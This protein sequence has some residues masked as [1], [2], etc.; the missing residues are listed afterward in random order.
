MG[1]VRG[2]GLWLRTSRPE[3]TRL[4][5]DFLWRQWRQLGLGGPGGGRWDPWILDPEALLLFSLEVGRSDPILY[6]QVLGWLARHERLINVSRLVR[7]MGRDSGF[8]PSLV[9]SVARWLSRKSS[10][11]KWKGLEGRKRSPLR[12]FFLSGLTGRL[13]GLEGK[14]PEFEAC[15]WDR[16]PVRP[17]REP[18]PIPILRVSSLVLRLRLLLGV[19]ARADLVAHLLCRAEGASPSAMADELGCSQPAVSQLCRDME[20]S[21]LLLVRPKGR[22]RLYRLDDRRWRD[23]L[24]LP[25]KTL[26]WIA[27]APLFRALVMVFRFL[28]REGA[29]DRGDSDLAIEL[30][31]IVRSFY[32]LVGEAGLLVPMSNIEVV[33]ED[34]LITA[35]ARDMITLLREGLGTEPSVGA[36]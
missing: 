15:G 7:I 33:P 5:Q 13:A 18:A 28:T 24:A 12:P 19:N 1:A 27:W 31:D 21:G 26:A 2:L 3:L 20:R 22:S 32:P 16:P 14:A 6:D 36:R 9:H 10:S 35:F 11:S 34:G 4:L 30:R 8:D 29:E 23:F 25:D 17:L